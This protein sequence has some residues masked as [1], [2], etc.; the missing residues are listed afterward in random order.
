MPVLPFGRIAPGWHT[1]TVEGFTYRPSTSGGNP[2]V[3]V[4]ATLDSGELTS[5]YLVVTTDGQAF[6]SFLI[7]CGE[8]AVADQLVKKR[9]PSFE[10]DDLIGR[11]LR[12]YIPDAGFI[13]KFMP[14]N[15]ID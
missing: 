13:S 8:R 4:D 11:S 3:D 9:N 1:A 7:A 2:M 6:A 10:L 14:I 5:I 12:V 15:P